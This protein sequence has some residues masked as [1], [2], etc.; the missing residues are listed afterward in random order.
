VPERAINSTPNGSCSCGSGKAYKTCHGNVATTPDNFSF[1]QVG[2]EDP[3]FD[4]IC[5]VRYE[6]YS[7][8]QL[9]LDTEGSDNGQTRDQWDQPSVHIAATNT[10]LHRVA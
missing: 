6:V 4:E 10:D 8:K 9:L 5:R 3:K 2:Q 1:L 7:H